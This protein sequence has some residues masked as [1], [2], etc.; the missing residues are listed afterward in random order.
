MKKLYYTSFFYA[1][2]GLLAG[3]AYREITKANDFSGNT[4]FVALHTHILMLGFFF[5]II[6]LILAKLFHV[7]EA[8]SF[9]AWYILYNIGLLISIGAMATRG[10]L[11]IKGGDISFLPHIAGLGH[12]IVGASIIWLLILLGK[13]LK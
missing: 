1:V 10:M 5:F 9:G 11:Q 13:R 12:A 6:T 2:L 8:K 3:V 7:H 4:V